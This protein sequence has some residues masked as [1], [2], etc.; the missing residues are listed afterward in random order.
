MQADRQSAVT[1][2]VRFGPKADIGNY[3]TSLSARSTRAAGMVWFIALAVLRLIDKLNVLGC[4]IG[5]SAVLA[6]YGPSFIEV[7]RGAARL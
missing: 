1:V 2:D 4:S 3:S 6:G 7:F 5:K